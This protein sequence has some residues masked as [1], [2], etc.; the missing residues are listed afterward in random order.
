[1]HPQIVRHVVD[2][3][4]RHTQKT[5][6]FAP[7]PKT[8]PPSMAALTDEIAKRLNQWSLSKEK[9]LEREVRGEEVEDHHVHLAEG[10]GVREI[11]DRLG[12]LRSIAEA[13][14]SRG[15]GSLGAISPE[16]RAMVLHALCEQVL[17]CDQ[18]HPN[19]DPNP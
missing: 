16:Q 6:F 14:H 1:M 2:A 3:L 12:E 7:N 11:V 19:P 15:G 9:C 10:S 18:I 4:L 17:N 8:G 5:I 13:V